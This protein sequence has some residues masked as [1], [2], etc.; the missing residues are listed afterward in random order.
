[1]LQGPR[2]G[3]TEQWL[4]NFA[5]IG[6]LQTFVAID[7]V[8]LHFLAGVQ[9]AVSFLLN[10]GEVDKDVLSSFVCDEPISFWVL[11]PLH[12]P[13]RHTTSPLPGPFAGED[14]ACV[15][16]LFTDNSRERPPICQGNRSE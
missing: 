6:G 10:G 7:D 13:P 1:M 9:A 16:V 11:K 12:L 14:P 5:H 8:K 15:G 3:R 2:G 4:G